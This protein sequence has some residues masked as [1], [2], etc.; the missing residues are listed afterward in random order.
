MIY[1]V[2]L[3]RIV[4]FVLNLVVGGPVLRT[5][6]LEKYLIICRQAPSLLVINWGYI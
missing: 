6:P 2:Y 5:T 4:R 3:F 1:M